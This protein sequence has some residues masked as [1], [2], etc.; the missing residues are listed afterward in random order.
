MTT[1]LFCEDCGKSLT[2]HDY[3]VWDDGRAA[4]VLCKYGQLF[5]NESKIEGY[6]LQ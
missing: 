5:T 4:H 6:I 1:E 3:I 2:G